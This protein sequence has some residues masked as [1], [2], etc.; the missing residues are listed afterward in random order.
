MS[1]SADENK[2]LHRNKEVDFYGKQ[3]YTPRV[4][5]E[6]KCAGDATDI[7][8]NELTKELTD[9]MGLD[10]SYEEGDWFELTPSENGYCPPKKRGE[11]VFQ[12]VV[13]LR[14]HA[15]RWQVTFWLN[16]E[17]PAGVPTQGEV[18]NMKI[19]KQLGLECS[20]TAHQRPPS[21]STV[22]KEPSLS[23][24]ALAQEPSALVNTVVSLLGT[25]GT[26]TIRDRNSYRSSAPTREGLQPGCS[27]TFAGSY[28]H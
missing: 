5:L 28:D 19:E 6:C 4:T 25:M 11:I 14:N 1:L 2:Y 9:M 20:V 13:V 16:F 3:A 24:S 22:A 18:K 15:S 26:A 8:L 17:G 12:C 23:S 10:W 27:A 21:V 7:P